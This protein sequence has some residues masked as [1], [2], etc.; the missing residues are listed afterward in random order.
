MFNDNTATATKVDL[1]ADFPVNTRNT[2]WY[3]VIIV[4]KKNSSTMEIQVTNLTTGITSSTSQDTNLPL[5]NQLLAWQ[6]WRQNGGTALAVG[7]DV[8]NIYIES[9]N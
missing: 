5:A 1:G 2:D 7:L 4:A 9:D 6:L 8:G 3:E